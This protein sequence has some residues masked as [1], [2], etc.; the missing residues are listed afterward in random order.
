MEQIQKALMNGEINFENEKVKT[1]F[2]LNLCTVSIS[3]IIEYN[4][5]VIL[6]QEYDTILNNL[7]IEKMP[8][9]GYNGTRICG[10]NP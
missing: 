4:D 6:E 5:I 7:N 10:G 8:N 2:A 3:Q 9:S 1:A